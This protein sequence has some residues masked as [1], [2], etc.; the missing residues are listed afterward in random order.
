MTE[1]SKIVWKND[2]YSKPME[3]SWQDRV[4]ENHRQLRLNCEHLI[5]SKVMDIFYWEYRSPHRDI[6]RNLREQLNG[7]KQAISSL[8]HMTYEECNDL[9]REIWAGLVS[10]WQDEQLD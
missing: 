6:A 5:K 7:M 2:R 9:D 4:A 3:Q 10:L 8:G 1:K